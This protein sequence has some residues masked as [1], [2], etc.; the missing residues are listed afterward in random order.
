LN[1]RAAGDQTF[2]PNFRYGCGAQ[3]PTAHQR[4][5]GFKDVGYEALGKGP[6]GE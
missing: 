3:V 4:P 5:L 2:D 6:D 1:I